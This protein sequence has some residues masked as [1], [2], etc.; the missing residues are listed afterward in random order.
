MVRPSE[1]QTP[2]LGHRLDWVMLRSS[3]SLLLAMLVQAR[4][5]VAVRVLLVSTL[6]A[7]EAGWQAASVHT[8]HPGRGLNRPRWWTGRVDARCQDTA[9]AGE[10]LDGGS[11]DE[12]S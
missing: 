9:G 8:V 6:V 7:R 12:D 3:R 11:V 4:S 5:F 1:Q 10:H 2:Q